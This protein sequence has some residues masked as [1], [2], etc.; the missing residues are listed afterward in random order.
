MDD[1]LWIVSLGDCYIEVKLDKIQDLPNANFRR[2]L[3]IARSNP[4]ENAAG[5]EQLREYLEAAVETSKKDWIEAGRTF[6]N[7]W[8]YVENKRSRD[9]KTVEILKRNKEL[10]QVCARARSLNTR[11]MS[12]LNIFNEE[13]EKNK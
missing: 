9:P 7:E 2:I 8:R 5:L 11:L 3:K 10:K 1:P 13:K 6:S 4:E 12:L